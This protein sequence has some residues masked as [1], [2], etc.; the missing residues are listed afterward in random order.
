MLCLISDF[1]TQHFGQN[2]N[3]NNVL[4]PY[5][6]GMKISLDTEILCVMRCI[7]VE[8]SNGA[9]IVELGVIGMRIVFR[10]CVNNLL[11]AEDFLEIQISPHIGC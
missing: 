10:T 8:I 2:W 9:T 3:L 4:V 6:V 11:F 7:V 5:C 1:P